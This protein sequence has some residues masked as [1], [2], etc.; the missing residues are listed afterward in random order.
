[1]KDW[2]IT[3][4]PDG[5]MRV[6]NES[7]GGKVV[8]ADKGTLPDRLLFALAQAIV[9]D[10]QTLRTAVADYMFSEGCGCCSDREEHDAH[11]ARLGQLLDVPAE[12]NGDGDVWYNFNPYRTPRP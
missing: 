6:F 1:M 11:K 5:G 3:Q 7:V 9:K 2:T 12:P 4:D 8:Y 10:E